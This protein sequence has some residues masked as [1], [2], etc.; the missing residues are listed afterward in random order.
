MESLAGDAL[1]VAEH[2]DQVARNAPTI[3]F[4]LRESSVELTDSVE[5][6]LD[7]LANVGA[8]EPVPDSRDYRLTEAG[9]RRLVWSQRWSFV[10]HD[11]WE[12]S[13]ASKPLLQGRIES[14]VIRP[15]DRFATDGGLT[16]RVKAI[17]MISGS[18]VPAD[19]VV[20][21]VDIDGVEIGD[22]LR[23][24]IPMA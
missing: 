23:V 18:R 9:R 5:A 11:S 15:G 14:G 4:L 21:N 13:I 16:G 1:A 2:L 12:L 3:R 20:L 8:A 10:V 7:H 24:W 22:V 19:Q 17:E 6:V